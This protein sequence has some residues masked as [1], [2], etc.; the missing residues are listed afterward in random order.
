MFALQTDEGTVFR[1]L[2]LLIKSPTEA[3]LDPHAF[4]NAYELIGTQR[5]QLEQALV[6]RPDRAPRRSAWNRLIQSLRRKA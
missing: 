6:Q 1:K 5:E 2:P 3:L 4:A